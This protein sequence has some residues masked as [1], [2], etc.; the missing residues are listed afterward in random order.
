MAMPCKLP[1]LKGINDDT[2]LSC[3][4]VQQKPLPCSK[5]FLPAN[6]LL[7]GEIVFVAQYDGWETFQLN[8]L[9]TD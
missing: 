8:C 2:L 9:I 7:D 5:S 3:V 4:C 6:S 1:L